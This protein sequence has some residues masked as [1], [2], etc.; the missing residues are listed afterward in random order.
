MHALSIRAIATNR[1]CQAKPAGSQAQRHRGRAGCGF[2]EPQSFFAYLPKV[3]RYQSIEIPVRDA[4]LAPS[5]SELT[6]ESNGR[7][8]VIARQALIFLVSVPGL[9]IGRRVAP[10]ANAATSAILVQEGVFRSP[11]S[12]R[13]PRR[14]AIATASVR[15]VAFPKHAAHRQVH[16]RTVTP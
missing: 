9:R 12:A 10:A 8:K 2:S 1:A 6:C 16:T 15:L 3:R 4:F 7:A 5:S 13:S 11:S 14:C